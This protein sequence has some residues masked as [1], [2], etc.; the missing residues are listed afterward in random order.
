MAILAGNEFPDETQIKHFVQCA[1]QM[2]LRNFAGK[3]KVVEH[4]F[5]VRFNSHYGCYPLTPSVT[6]LF[7]D[8]IKC[9]YSVS[10]ATDSMLTPSPIPLFDGFYGIN[11]RTCY[12][13]AVA[14]PFADR[15][16]VLY[17]Y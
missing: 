14:R 12:A 13:S 16:E 8:D 2:I 9:L 1:H 7:T 4:S 11:G 15:V 17:I 3:R 6:S 5:L 10:S